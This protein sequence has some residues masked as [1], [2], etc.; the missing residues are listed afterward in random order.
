MSNLFLH[1]DMI[2]EVLQA[3]V[4]KNRSSPVA[5]D[6]IHNLKKENKIDDYICHN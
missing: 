4:Y 5:A 1:Y 3:I 6:K 2:I